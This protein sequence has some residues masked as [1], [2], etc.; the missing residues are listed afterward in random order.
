MCARCS[1]HTPW[2][3]ELC[4]HTDGKHPSFSAPAPAEIL[5]FYIL[6]KVYSFDSAPGIFGMGKKWKIP[7]CLLFSIHW[8]RYWSQQYWKWHCKLLTKTETRLTDVDGEL[9][10]DNYC[11]NFQHRWT[12]HGALSLSDQMQIIYSLSF[13]L[14][15][16]FEIRKSEGDREKE[17][18]NC[19]LCLFKRI[20]LKW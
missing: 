6:L 5:C 10:I 8:C 18:G 13:S 14:R 15:K 2:S 20:L 17:R 1:P 11:E 4:V 7:C 16:K 19:A 12:R 9:F 3:W